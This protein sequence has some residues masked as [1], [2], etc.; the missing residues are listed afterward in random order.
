MCAAVKRRGDLI[1]FDVDE[2]GFCCGGAAVHAQDIFMAGDDFAFLGGQVG[3]PALRR[4][5]AFE[6]FE[7]NLAAFEQLIGRRQDTSGD[8]GHQGRAVSFEIRCLLGNDEFDLGHAFADE[9]QDVLVLR[10]PA[11]EQHGS[12]FNF[13]P[14]EKIDDF[15][16]HDIAQR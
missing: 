12:F 11:D 2:A 7:L 3:D 5:Q 6:S 15:D 4:L 14:F 9:A 16:G 8:S 13:S 10:Y 1:G